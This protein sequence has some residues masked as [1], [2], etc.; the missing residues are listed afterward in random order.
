[1]STGKR[2]TRKYVDFTPEEIKKYLDDLRRL[3]LDGMYVI[4]KNENRQENNDFI[5]EYKIDSKKEKEILL[6]LQFDDFCY[7]VDNE[8]EEFAHERLY[9]FCKEYELDNWGTLE[10][11]EI[12]IKTNMTK[13]RRGEEYMIVVSFH[14][15]N[16]PITYLF[17]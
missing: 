11:V 14:K 10:C 12:Y 8:K 2:E 16:K 5:E 1:M 17:K 4:S 3:V 7:A 9:I 15:R 6:S 13:T